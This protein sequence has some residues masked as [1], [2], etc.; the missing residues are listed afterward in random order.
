MKMRTMFQSVF[1]KAALATAA[2]GGFLLFA[3]APGAKANDWDDC[4]RRISYTEWRYHEAVEHFGP[5]S[6]DAQHW[7]HE[8]QEAYQRAEHLRHEYREHHRDRDDRY[9]GDWDRR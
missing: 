7:Y 6:R 4:N 5:Y 3:G 2:L 9:R 8:R 1:G